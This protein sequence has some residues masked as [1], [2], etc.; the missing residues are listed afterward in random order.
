MTADTR[1]QLAQSACKLKV[2]ELAVTPLQVLEAQQQPYF[3]EFARMCQTVPDLNPMLD[4][5]ANAGRDGME[6]IAQNVSGDQTFMTDRGNGAVDAVE[7]HDRIEHALSRLEYTDGVVDQAE[8]GVLLADIREQLEALPTG[9]LSL[10]VAKQTGLRL[11]SQRKRGLA[12][13][14]GS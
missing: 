9:G 12:L 6:F 4:M 14:G 5:V 7:A 8:V 10:A 3:D 1:E 2:P 11:H 13:L